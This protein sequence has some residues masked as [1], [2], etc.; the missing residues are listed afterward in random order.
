[1]VWKLVLRLVRTLPTPLTLIVSWIRFGAILVV[2][3]LLG[4]SRE[5]AADVGR[6]ISD[7]MLLTPVIR[8]RS[9][10]FLMNCPF[11]LTLLVTLKSRIVFAFPGV[12]A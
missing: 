1:M 3:R 10:R 8:S 5:R 2:D 4:A 11:V 12:H 9:L 7:S 6:T